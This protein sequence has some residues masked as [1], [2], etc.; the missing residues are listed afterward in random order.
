MKILIFGVKGFIGQNL[1]NYLQREGMDVYGVSSSEPNTIDPKTGVLSPHFN[2]LPHTDVIIYLSQSPFYRQTPE[3]VNHLYN[4]N[5]LSAVELAKLAIKTNVKK[6]IYTSTG[7]VY[8]SSFQPL[9]ETAPLNRNN[10]YGLSKIHAEE[11][12]N[13]FKDD[14]DIIIT[15]I[16]GVYGERQ[17]NK[18]IPNLINSVCNN[19]EI[20]ID[21]NPLDKNDLEG[22]KISLIYIQDLVKIIKAMIIAPEQKS[23][24]VINLSSDETLS[25]KKIVHII[26]NKINKEPILKLLDRDRSGDLIAD[27]SLLK[28]YI[29]Y[30]FTP[31]KVGVDKMLTQ[32]DK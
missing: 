10:W 31:F 32:F 30:Q 15:R 8:Q 20:F 1:S 16:F 6:F 19:K 24:Q 5:V 13:L 25:L 14:L 27:I 4:V 9:V 7:N 28:K 22:L 11:T 2:I 17:E 23:K 26:S 29:N 18:L 3:K 12:L 21:Q